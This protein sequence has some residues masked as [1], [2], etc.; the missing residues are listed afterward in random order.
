MPCDINLEKIHKTEVM[1]RINNE[2]SLIPGSSSTT[3]QMFCATLTV[4][5]HVSTYVAKAP[6]TGQKFGEGTF[7]LTRNG[8]NVRMM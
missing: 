4:W 5:S 7:Q 1:Q 6:Q 3:V 2:K 8:F